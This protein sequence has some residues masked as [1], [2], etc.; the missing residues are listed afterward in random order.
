MSNPRNVN[1]VLQGAVATQR[2]TLPALRPARVDDPGLSELLNA[3][4]ER[5]EI[6][7]GS[8]EN[9]FERAVTLR[10]LDDL[11]LVRTAPAPGATS[12]ISGVVVQ[13]P[14]G[15]FTVMPFT[16]LAQVIKDTNA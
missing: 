8:R 12:A 6:R 16:A 1:L 10:D 13:T 15:Q 3:I 2:A 9:P 11:G 4:K 7:E 14:D 5:L